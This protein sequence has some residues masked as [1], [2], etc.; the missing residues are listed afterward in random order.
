ME[1]LSW[2]ETNEW[3]PSVLA[4]GRI[5]YPHPTTRRHFRP[6]RVECVYGQGESRWAALPRHEHLI[7]CVRFD[8]LIV[9]SVFRLPGRWA[10][11][12]QNYV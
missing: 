2:H 3:H 5:V 12:Y 4:D 1:T 7:S 6:P 11:N 8:M 10:Q 9:N